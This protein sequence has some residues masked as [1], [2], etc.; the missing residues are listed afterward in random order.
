MI[1]ETETDSFFNFFKTI[2][3]SQLN[4]EDEKVI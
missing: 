2:D 1:K 4:D 3:T